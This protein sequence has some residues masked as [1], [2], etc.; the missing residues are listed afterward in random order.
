MACGWGKNII[1]SCCTLI[2]FVIPVDCPNFALINYCSE[3]ALK[4]LRFLLNPL[5]DGG[6]KAIDAM[7]KHR[8]SLVNCKN[9]ANRSVLCILKA[10]VKIQF[11]FDSIGDSESERVHSM[12]GRCKQFT[13][14]INILTMLTVACHFHVPL[15]GVWARWNIK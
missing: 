10:A 13:Y 8:A 12:R 5:S 6:S 14:E 15:N 4:C 11:R 7:Q 1:S 9:N 2:R 3:G